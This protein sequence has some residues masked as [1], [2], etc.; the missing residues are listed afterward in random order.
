[1]IA[2]LISD[3]RL[4]DLFCD[5]AARGSVGSV[6]ILFSALK[7]KVFFSVLRTDFLTP[8]WDPEDP[9]EVL[10]VTERYTVR[11]AAL[12]ARGYSI[13]DDQM[14]AQLYF[15]RKWTADE[16]I[17]YLLMPI[18]P[19]AEPVRDSRRSL[20]HGLGFVPIVWIRNLPGEDD[21]D[22]APTFEAAISTVINIDYTLSQSGRAMKYAGDPKLVIQ[23]KD[24][25]DSD[26]TND[27]GGGAFNMLVVN[28]GEAKLLE[29]NGTAAT[30]SLEYVRYLRA[31]A[32]ESVHGNRTDAEKMSAAQSGRATEMMNQGLI[33]LADRMRVS[34][35]QV[36]LLSLLRMVCRAS[37]VISPSEGGLIIAGKRVKALDPTGLS[38]VWPCWYALTSEDRKSEATMLSKLTASGLLSRDAARRTLASTYDI[39]DQEAERLLIAA[40]EAAADATAALLPA[41]VNQGRRNRSGLTAENAT[42]PE[43]SYSPERNLADCL[44]I[45]ACTPPRSRF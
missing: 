1:M 7:S 21:I 10:S 39:E 5:A 44:L 16:E 9:D 45:A 18:S 35:G 34:Y 29:I 37:S 4:N 2:D 13:A 41:R 22:G 12:A 30:A 36:G 42:P 20:K 24:S 15:E 14:N 33:W 38:L 19:A 28:N 31:L 6:A 43:G 25:N 8:T 3:R 23:T 27:T 11:G 17:W 32:L 40:D 26:K